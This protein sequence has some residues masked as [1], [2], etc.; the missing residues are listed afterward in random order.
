MFAM[1]T[2]DQLLAR[3]EPYGQQHVLKF[4][5]ELSA[6]QRQRLADQVRSIELESLDALLRSDEAG[7]D[8]AALARRAVA[9]PA[10]RLHTDSDHISREEARQQGEREL[11][12][13]RLGVIIVAGGQ[14][15]RLGFDAPKGMYPIGPVSGASL[16][17]ILVE[18]VVALRRRYKVHIPL[19]VMTSPATHAPT[20]SFFA[21]H[22]RF[23]LPSED[24]KI[25]SQGTM[26]AVDARTHRLLL[27]AKDSLALSPDGHGGTLEALERSGSLADMK[28]RG[29]KHLFYLQV[30]NPLTAV[31]DPSFVGY[32]VLSGSELSTAVKAKVAAEE[33]VGNVVSVDGCVRIIEYSDLPAE[34]AC[35]QCED[36]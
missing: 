24:L 35:R 9:P 34:A 29:L 25:F 2:K 18:K 30:D 21:E 7:E 27:S 15:T 31:G 5:D 4:W 3:L 20:V 28:R 11:R 12:A 32:H 26:P 22:E 23:G 13:G 17:Q 36:G 8:W 10:F 33:K 16:F 19:Y 14:G 1:T 6:D